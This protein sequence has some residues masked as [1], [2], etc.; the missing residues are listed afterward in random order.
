MRGTTNRLNGCK[1]PCDNT[2]LKRAFWIDRVILL[3]L[4]AGVVELA[5]T[6]DLKSLG[7]SPRAGSSPAPGTRL[8]IFP[9]PSFIPSTT[10]SITYKIRQFSQLM[11]QTLLHGHL[12]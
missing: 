8:Q 12:P 9:T 5:D 2:L 11:P 6:R 4:P 1:V 10:L 7:A 3:R